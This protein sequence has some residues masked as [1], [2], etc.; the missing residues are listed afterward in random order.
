MCNCTSGIQEIINEDSNSDPNLENYKLALKNLGI[1][2]KSAHKTEEGKKLSAEYWTD[3]VGLLKKAKLGVSM[4]ELGIDDEDEIQSTHDATV[5]KIKPTPAGEKGEG[6]PRDG[7]AEAP[8]EEPKKEDSDD[9]DEDDENS[10]P[11]NEKSSS[12]SQQR[13]FGMVH[14]YNKGDLKKSDVNSDLYDKVKKIANGMTQDDAEDMA[15]TDHNDLPEKVPTDEFYDTMNHLSILL[16]EQSFDNVESDGSQFNINTDNRKFTI[17]FDDKFYM[18]SEKYNFELGTTYDL[19]EV[20]DTFVKLSKH[21]DF[22]LK[23]DYEASL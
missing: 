5:K 15:K 17:K 20:V 21:S 16:S 1:A 2:I 6:G 12:K 11:L 23:R 8:T 19:K 22:V 3:I 10:K 4:M 7:G 14:A 13:L 9:E 18:V